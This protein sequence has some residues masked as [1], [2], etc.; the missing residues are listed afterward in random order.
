MNN[1]NEIKNDMPMCV[2]KPYGNPIL[3]D[4]RA[5]VNHASVFDSMVFVF[6]RL[7]DG[8]SLL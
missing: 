2:T 8:V 7:D 4:M 5:N 6:P 3:T 1:S